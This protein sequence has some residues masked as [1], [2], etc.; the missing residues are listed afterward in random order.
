VTPSRSQKSTP[1]RSGAGHLP[2]WVGSRSNWIWAEYQFLDDHCFERS[3]WPVIQPGI[4]L[5]THGRDRREAR[6]PSKYNYA[7]ECP[8]NCE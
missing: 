8:C 2:S 7:Q 4:R 3:K 1:V 5:E 6:A